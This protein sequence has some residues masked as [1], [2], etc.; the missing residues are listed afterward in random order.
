[1]A[2]GANLDV[3]VAQIDDALA[4]ILEESRPHLPFADQCYRST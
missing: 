4:D 3:D 1:M 2:G